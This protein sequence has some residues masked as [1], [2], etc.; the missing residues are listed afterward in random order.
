MRKT[1]ERKASE[2]SAEGM[3]DLIETIMSDHLKSNQSVA[4]RTKSNQERAELY[5]DLFLLTPK[6]FK[7]EVTRR[8]DGQSDSLA[9]Q[10][11]PQE[12]C[13][14]SKTCHRLASLTV[15]LRSSNRDI[16]LVAVWTSP[17]LRRFLYMVMGCLSAECSSPYTSARRSECLHSN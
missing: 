9:H 4:N 8:H 15:I 13:P 7:I 6:K 5:Y 12:H 17:R 3:M 16:C 1:V 11:S 14:F 10:K 2:P